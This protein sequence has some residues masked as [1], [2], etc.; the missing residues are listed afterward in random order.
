MSGDGKKDKT[1]AKEGDQKGGNKDAIKKGGAIKQGGGDAKKCCKDCGQASDDDAVD[2]TGDGKPE[3]TKKDDFK[4][5][6]SIY[7][8]DAGT[9][10]F[11]DAEDA[12][13]NDMKANN[14][15]WKEIATAVGASKEEVMFRFQELVANDKDKVST[16]MRETSIRSLE[17]RRGG[18]CI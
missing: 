12:K 8:V 4:P 13:I 3:K 15:S 18:A 2:K 1:K 5:F 7:D 11:T 16:S 14:K 10:L 9:E 6:G 17:I